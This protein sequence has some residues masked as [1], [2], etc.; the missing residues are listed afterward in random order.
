[1]FDDSKVFSQEFNINL[2][3]AKIEDVKKFG[4]IIDLIEIV[5]KRSVS[6]LFKKERKESLEK[7]RKLAERKKNFDEILLEIGSNV[8]AETLS[9]TP[10]S[11]WV[12]SYER[13]K[14][15]WFK[16]FFCKIK[17]NSSAK[18]IGYSKFV[19]LEVIPK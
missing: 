1:L 14:D 7:L 18:K 4:S 17:I 3:E 16:S 15:S 6:F 8:T 10:I 12:T 11:E 19:S 13:A 2:E 5:E 9:K